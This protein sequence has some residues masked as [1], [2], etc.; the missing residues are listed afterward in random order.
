MYRFLLDA[1]ETFNWF[2]PERMASALGVLLRGMLTVFA[3]LCIVWFALVLIRLLLGAFAGKSGEKKSE[4]PA[5]QPVPAPAPTAAPVQTDDALLVAIIT[6][7]IAAMREG[8]GEGD[9]GFCVV[10]F[11]RT[12]K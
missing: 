1:T 11:N 2:D 6:A 9:T 12:K 7:A 10:S 5:P 3:V 4:A 8:E